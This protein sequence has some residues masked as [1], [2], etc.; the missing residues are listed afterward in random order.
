MPEAQILLRQATAWI[1]SV[2]PHGVSMSVFVAGIV[3]L[4]F[5]FGRPLG[6]LIGSVLGYIL[7][8]LAVLVAWRLVG[9]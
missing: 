8:A 5:V 6:R 7:V 4:G 2:R 9:G 3:F 1:A